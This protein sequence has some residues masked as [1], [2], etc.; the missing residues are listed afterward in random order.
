MMLRMIFS[1]FCALSISLNV[2]AS[3]WYP[4]K[5]DP[6]LT[7]GALCTEPTELRYSEK[8]AYCERKVFGDEKW[9]VIANYMFIMPELIIT[10]NNRYH[11]KIDHFIPLCMGGSNDIKNLWPQHQDIYNHTDII[12]SE[13][14]TLLSEGIITQFEAIAQVKFAKM[15]IDQWKDST[16][17]IQF[18]QKNYFK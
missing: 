6:V 2:F 12:E 11:F 9:L 1:S 13:L 14:C 16:D 3:E 15:N 18:I 8:I 10:Q 7:P 5:P 17:P 4:L